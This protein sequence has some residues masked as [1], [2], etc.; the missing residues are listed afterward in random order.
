M[1]KEQLYSLKITLEA[2]HLIEWVG[3]YKIS[4]EFIPHE[5]FNGLHCIPSPPK[6]IYWSLNQNVTLFRDRGFTVV[7][8]VKLKSLGWV[9]IRMTGVLMKRETWTQTCT[10]GQHHI[11][12]KAIIWAITSASQGIIKINRK[13]PEAR[14][15][16]WD[17][18]FL[19]AL[20]RNQPCQHPDLGF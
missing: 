14:R 18:F 16:A 2:Y 6:K 3:N 20:S 12:M 15:E 5:D 19:T 11:K 8:Q 17:T 4:L 7:L 1:F 9:L 10:R 13:P